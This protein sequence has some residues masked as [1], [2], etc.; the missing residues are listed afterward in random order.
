MGNSDSLLYKEISKFSLT[1]TQNN[2]L[3]QLFQHYL[4]R[5]IDFLFKNQFIEILNLSN[6]E[7]FEIIFD[8]YSKKHPRYE[9]I[10]YFEHLKKLYYTLT[11][12]D[13]DIKIIFI[14]FLLFR[15][16]KQINK[17]TLNKNIKKIFTN[18]ELND[19]L[20]K[21]IAP[22]PDQDTESDDKVGKAKGKDKYYKRNQFIAWCKKNENINY[23]QQLKF[24]KNKIIG[25][26]EYSFNLKD[27]N[28]LNFICDCCKK[29][30]VKDNLDTM[31]DGFDNLTNRTK[32]V[33]YLKDF[34]K[35]LKKVGLNSKMINLII[36]YLK[37]YT[38]KDY[39]SFN[40]IKYIFSNLNNTLDLSIKKRFLFNMILNIYK[41]KSKLSYKQIYKY[42]YINSSSQNQ[43]II[44]EINNDNDNLGEINTESNFSDIIQNIEEKEPKK[45]ENLSFT[46]EE[47]LNS[48]NI[49]DNLFLR[50]IPQLKIVELLPY[51]LFNAKTKDKNI[52][53][54]LV[55]ETLKSKNIDDHEIYLEKSFDECNRFYA[56]DIN[57]WNALNSENKEIPDYIDNSRISE[58]IN[59]IK[60]EDKY[61]QEENE[62]QMEKNKKKEGKKKK[63]E[64]KDKKK[65]EDKNNK[66]KED[67]SKVDNKEEDKNKIDN[68]NEEEKEDKKEEIKGNKKEKKKDKDKDKKKEDNKPNKKEEDKDKNETEEKINQMKIKRA[69]LKKGLKYKQ[70][71]IVL[72]DELYNIINNNYKIDYEIKLKKSIHPYLIINNKKKE[73][74]KKDKK[75]CSNNAKEVQNKEQSTNEEKKE[76]KE[77]NKKKDEKKDEEKIKKEEEKIK[78]EKEEEFKEKEKI[79]NENL[80]HYNLD[81]EKGVI[82]K[83]IKDK[84]GNYI[85]QV[86]DFYPIEVYETSF[87][88]ILRTVEKQ[89]IIYDEIEE[90]KKIKKLSKREQTRIKNKKKKDENKLIEKMKK[91]NALKLHYEIEFQQKSIS[92]EDYIAKKKELRNKYSDVIDKIERKE[93]TATTYETD[94]TLSEFKD[95][96]QKYKNNILLEKTENILTLSRYRT[97]KEILDEMIMYNP[98]LASIK[99]DVYYFLTNSKQLLKP[100]KEQLLG[101]E[102]NEDFII[103]LIDIHNDNDM[104]F[105]Q[106]LQDKE[107]LNNTEQNP[108]DN[109]IESKKKKNET[110]NK[111]KEKEKNEGKDKEN[112]KKKEKEKLSKEEKEKLEKEKKEREKELKRMKKEVE[113]KIAQLKKEMKEKEKEENKKRKKLEKEREREKEKKIEREKYIAPPYGINNYG[114]TCYFNSVNQIFFNM[115]ILQQIFLDPRID[116]FINKMNKFGHQGKFFEKYKNLYWIKPSKVGDSVQSLKSL[117]G[118][119]KEDFNNNDQQDANEYLNFVIENLHEELNLYSAKRYIEEKDDIHNHNTEE[120]LGNISWANNLRRNASFIDSIFMFQLKSNLKC[121]KCK[122]KKVN[123]EANYIFD[124]PLSLCKMVNVEIYL[125]RLPFRYK[126]YYNKINEK[127]HKY[128]N[129]EKN[130]KLS[131]VKILWN[132]YTNVLTVEEKKEHYVQLHFSFDL[133]RE[134]KMSDITKILR[135]IKPLELEPEN[136]IE[137]INNE[138][139]IEYKIENYTDLITYSNEKNRIIYPNSS[140]DKYVNINDNIKLNIYEVL[141]TNGMRLLFEEENNN[142][143]TN[144]MLYSYI[145]KKGNILNLDDLKDQLIN[146]NYYIVSNKDKENIINEVKEENNINIENNQNKKIVK[147]ECNILSLR[148]KMIYFPKEVI[149]KITI[150]RKIKTEFA[151]PIYHYYRS[152]KDSVY[153]FRDAFHTKF[154]QFPIQY[155][156]LNNS[157]NIKAKQL[158][159]YIWNLNTLYMNHPNKNPD[160]FW[161]NVSNNE[162][163]N[164]IKNDIISIKMGK[165]LIII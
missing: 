44:E 65:E 93:K 78:K 156:I 3:L 98:N 113:K 51:L 128:K 18:T 36:D 124:L 2:K 132:Y 115:P 11:T 49:F 162:S 96:L 53:R 69:K 121:R 141:N 70:D 57:F 131:L 102:Q 140:I 129:E 52:K 158:Y 37:A 139:V 116:Y 136:A 161:W 111:E 28:K 150:K 123:F 126:L 109:E 12:V 154:I 104:S 47:F 101:K 63:E 146:T 22:L 125:F 135:G 81:E 21:I 143:K 25:S 100:E 43:Q 97:Y 19:Y 105:Y 16:E 118:K 34:N 50:L 23:F 83:I 39:C 157:Y 9:R 134:K 71:F 24:I 99:Y 5:N 152:S 55:V 147:K 164:I 119:L 62:E 38:Q 89:K 56:I 108:K 61:Y 59:I 94:I 142:I 29:G 155:V 133:E 15:N 88:H 80:N 7:L 77:N 153:L 159:E 67:I 10:I 75:E 73:E 114:N 68:K 95:N 144:L 107:Q 127:F 26:S 42:L 60:E 130:K 17:A 91:Y 41:E 45:F 8:L 122:T 79:A 66:K 86:L 148:E 27:N 151:I 54:R 138:K 13:S 1:E 145:I 90:Y 106:L 35:S 112:E 76:S 6:A 58:E 103:I 137:T 117:V 85:S 48:N 20:T 92:E 32:G 33:L 30:I 87:G 40:D 160:N 84:N 165:K 46:E 31:K 72:C 64:N 120:E 163:N 110:K 82:T 74:K 4:Y 14:S 149:K